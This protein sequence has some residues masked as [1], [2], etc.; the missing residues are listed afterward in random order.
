MAIPKMLTLPQLAEESNL[1]Y[2]VIRK[3]AL[4]GRFPY[5]RRGKRILVNRD[6]F[7]HYLETGDDRQEANRSND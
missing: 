3:M 7:Y 5:I 1:S 6:N 2:Q 4:E